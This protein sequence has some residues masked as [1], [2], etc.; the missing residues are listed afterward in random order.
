MQS[1]R[2][3]LFTDNLSFEP[4]KCKSSRTHNFDLGVLNLHI[5]TKNTTF[6]VG[7]CVV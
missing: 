7:H 3:A 5:I 2:E 6:V 1:K 4:G